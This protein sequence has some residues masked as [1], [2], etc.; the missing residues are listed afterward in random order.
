MT[1]VGDASSAAACGASIDGGDTAHAS[2]VATDGTGSTLGVEEAS[3]RFSRRL[4][5][6]LAGVTP[7][8][9]GVALGFGGLSDEGSEDRMIVKYSEV[10]IL[11]DQLLLPDRASWNTRDEVLAR[12]EIKRLVPFHVPWKNSSK[13]VT[14]PASHARL[15]AL[16]ARAAAGGGED[17]PPPPP[18]TSW[19]Q[20]HELCRGSQQRAPRSQRKS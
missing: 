6:I 8:P 17:A 7:L 1:N 18:A 11:L 2:S 3:M 20:S 9:D 19:E 4:G 15:K 14:M 12:L 16:A 13:R 5:S 10:K